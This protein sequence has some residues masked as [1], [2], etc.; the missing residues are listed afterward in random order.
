MGI[1]LDQ[2]G[3]NIT[4]GRNVRLDVYLPIWSLGR[5]TPHLVP[6]A[7]ETPTNAGVTPR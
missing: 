7:G 2:M 3:R 5:K 1:K 6:L 4:A